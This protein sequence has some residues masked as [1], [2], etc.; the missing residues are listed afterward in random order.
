MKIKI[1]NVEAKTIV[2]QKA[3]NGSINQGHMA[4]EE[5]KTDIQFLKGDIVGQ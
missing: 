4:I 1:A 5:V 3:L 2:E